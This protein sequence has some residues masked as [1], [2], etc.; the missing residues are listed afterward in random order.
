M[1]R[2]VVHQAEQGQGFRE[3]RLKSEEDFDN[4]GASAAALNLGALGIH[5]FSPIYSCKSSSTSP[6]PSS[7]YKI[8]SA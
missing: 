5:A 7:C 6:S 4:L 3:K 8:A 2:R 1:Q